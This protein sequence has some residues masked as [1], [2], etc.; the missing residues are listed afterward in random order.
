MAHQLAHGIG[1]QLRVG[2]YTNHI[3]GGAGCYSTV[4]SRCLSAI[5]L[6]YNRNFRIVS[7]LFACP[8]QRIVAAPIVY[9]I[10]VETG[11]VL[12]FKVAD[13]AHNVYFFVVGRHDN[14]YFRSCSGTD[15]GIVPMVFCPLFAHHKYVHKEQ[16]HKSEHQEYEE[17]RREKVADV[18]DELG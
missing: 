6:L 3:F 17:Q 7:E 15:G 14:R 5:F 13:G 2:I 12:L 16:A 11:V 10:D 1:L 18:V 4:Q 8:R 9:Q